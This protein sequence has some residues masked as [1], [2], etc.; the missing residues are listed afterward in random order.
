MTTHFTD[1]RNT[2]VEHA[3]RY[4]NPKKIE[5][6]SI[7]IKDPKRR[8]LIASKSTKALKEVFVEANIILTFESTEKKEVAAHL[9]LPQT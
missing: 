4:V 2:T 9:S 7:D 3:Q 8:L 5:I 6:E 1:I